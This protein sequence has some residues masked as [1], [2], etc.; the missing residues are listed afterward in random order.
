MLDPT[1]EA[2]DQVTGLV[3]FAVDGAQCAAV[4]TWGMTACAPLAVIASI[5]GW[6]S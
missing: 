5:K 4:G 6:E 2:L 1:E 3:D